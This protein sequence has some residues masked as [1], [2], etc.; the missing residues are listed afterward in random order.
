MSQPNNDL[1][2]KFGARPL[3]PALP[4]SELEEEAPPPLSAFGARPLTERPPEAPAADLAAFGARRLTPEITGPAPAPTEDAARGRGVGQQI[5]SGIGQGLKEALVPWAVTKEELKESKTGAE[6]ASSVTANL[7]AGLAFP[8]IGFALAGP[9]GAAVGAAL[10]GLYA[11]IGNETMRSKAND[12]DFSLLRAAGQVALEVNPLIKRANKAMRAVRAAAQVG[13]AYALER[14]Y[15]TEEPLA[16]AVGTLTQGLAPVLLTKGFRPDRAFAPPQAVAEAVK[17]LDP[18]EAGGIASRTIQR[19]SQLPKSEL[20][21]D[22]GNDQFRR[23]LVG[24]GSGTKADVVAER[25]DEL[26]KRYGEPARADAW[27]MWKFERTLVEEAEGAAQRQYST[28]TGRT[29]S[30]PTSALGRTFKDGQLV[31]NDLD[32]KLGFNMVGELDGFSRGKDAFTTA[33]AQPYKLGVEARH[34]TRNLK[35]VSEESVGKALAGEWDRIPAAEARTLEGEA[36]TAVLAKWRAA[37]DSVFRQVQAAGYE[38]GRLDNFFPLHAMRGADLGLALERGVEQIKA[39]AVKRQLPNLRDVAEGDEEAQELLG[40]IASRLKKPINELD[41]KDIFQAPRQLISQELKEGVGYDP[42]TLHLRAGSLP[43]SVREWRPG[44][45]L[46][47]YINNNLKGVYMQ[48]PF[49]RMQAHVRA[50]D[51]LG[52]TKTADFYRR[53]LDDMSGV[54]RGTQLVLGEKAEA[55]RMWG[56][57]LAE[58]GGMGTVVGKT[59]AAVPEL[60]GI[61]SSGLYPAYLG[62]NVRATLRNLTQT[63]ATTAPEIGGAYGYSLVARGTGAAAKAAAS[64]VSPAEFLR[65]RG[66][67]AGHV[68]AEAAQVL[69][70]SKATGHI[71]Q[72]YD[73]YNELLM[74]AYSATDTSN[75]FITMHAGHEWAKDLIAGD[76]RALKALTRMQ[77]GAREALLPNIKQLLEEKNSAQLGN[78]LGDY[79]VGRTQFRY[80]K[81]QLNEFGRVMGPVVSMFSKWPVMVSSDI[82][83]Q[84]RHKGF[85]GGGARVLEKYAAPYLALHYMSTAIA[86]QTEL[87]KS[88]AYKYLVGNLPSLS[89]LEAAFTWDL[90]GG[91]LVRAPAAIGQAIK[92]PTSAGQAVVREVLKAAPVVGPVINEIDR[93][94][95]AQDKVTFTTQKLN[96]AKKLVQRAVEGPLVPEPEPGAK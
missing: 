46:T 2:A 89:P 66:Q 18:T 65:T 80:G 52:L 11:G 17:A 54:A 79:L 33:A 55:M 41:N 32:E 19:F 4:A 9:P 78:I 60:F 53:Y 56:R 58:R 69:D 10:Y 37:F 45:M 3:Q 40:F 26:W 70:P 22:S 77:R 20:A 50:L 64:G 81:E 25:F 86:E 51:S 84:F 1:L 61:A 30:E 48:T 31:A 24:A 12:E 73:K 74:A 49:R 34:A 42:T 83:N 36:G 75:R 29:L 88:P 96:Q 16:L 5:A 76:A 35:G 72:A 6:I 8:V 43:D 85:V 62:A 87:E 94:Y 21:P 93:I 39:R 7:G 68:G 63:W 91:P 92:E 23:W 27:G 15:G 47:F 44:E 13:G 67:L 95:R 14:S 28:L 38:P 71:R 90:A 59:A 82:I 57:R